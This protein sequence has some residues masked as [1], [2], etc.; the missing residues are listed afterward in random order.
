MEKDKLLII[1]DDEDLRKQMK[2]GL[3][4]DFEVFTAED[5]PR[6]LE[7]FNEENPPIVTLD[8]GLP[9]QPVGVE[10]GFSALGEMLEQ[11]PLSKVIVITG[12]DDRKHALAAISQG[13]YDFLSK[14]VQLD[15]LQIILKRA[16]HVA[17]LEREHRKLQERLIQESFESML[18]TSPQMQ[19]VFD[20]IRKVS[21]TD[22][23]VLIEEYSDFN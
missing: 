3:S 21:T 4:R 8:L 17:R 5:R 11:D 6:G 1:E 14:P 15:E 22:A 23:P 20:A 9:P 7:I 2:W 16:Q 10:E 19:E 18:G 13:A 12:R